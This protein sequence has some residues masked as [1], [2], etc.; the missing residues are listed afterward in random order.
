MFLL[1]LRCAIWRNCLGVT[2]LMRLTLLSMLLHR[3]IRALTVRAQHHLLFTFS[4]LSFLFNRVV[5][6]TV[7]VTVLW[8]LRRSHWSWSIS[9]GRQSIKIKCSNPTIHRRSDS[10]VSLIQHIREVFNNFLLGDLEGW[11]VSTRISMRLLG[12]R[13][14]LDRLT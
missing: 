4:W 9:L 3:Q 6:S 5:W 8:R 11:R 10:F 13:V 12:L 1:T 7:W 2:K 14:Y